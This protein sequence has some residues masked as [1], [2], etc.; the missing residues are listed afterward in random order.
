MYVRCCVPHGREGEGISRKGLVVLSNSP[1]GGVGSGRGKEEGW[2]YSSCSCSSKM[3]SEGPKDTVR[4]GLWLCCCCSGA[5][6]AE[7]AEGFLAEEVTTSPRG[8]V[9][10]PVFLK[11]WMVSVSSPA[12]DQ[13]R[14]RT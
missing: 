1:H 10:G 2:S 13:D 7:E 5:E 4:E 3:S 11:N 12:G 9:E 6:R 14:Q 8:R